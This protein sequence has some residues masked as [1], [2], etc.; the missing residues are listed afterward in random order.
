[1]ITWDFGPVQHVYLWYTKD[2]KKV[3]SF[4]LDNSNSD[5]GHQ[6]EDNRAG[7]WQLVNH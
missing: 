7:N 5:T 1:M 4:D 3:H 6:E 2:K